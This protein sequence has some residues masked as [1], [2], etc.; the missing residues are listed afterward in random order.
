MFAS[1]HGP[2]SFQA[3]LFLLPDFDLED[4]LKNVISMRLETSERTKRTRK[5]PAHLP[6]LQENWRY[7]KLGRRFSACFHAESRRWTGDLSSPLA[8]L[9]QVRRVRLRVSRLIDQ[10]HRRRS[11]CGSIRAIHGS[12]ARP[13]LTHAIFACGE[14]YA[15]QNLKAASCVSHRRGLLWMRK[16]RFRSLGSFANQQANPSY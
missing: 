6:Q 1:W 9:T 15:V 8:R 4:F 16:H 11:A 13:L 3:K 10:T 5:N 14:K 7:P 2:N 12:D